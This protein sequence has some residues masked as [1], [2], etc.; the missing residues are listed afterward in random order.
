M[1]KKT[2]AAILEKINKIVQ[3]TSTQAVISTIKKFHQNSKI[4]KV[5]KKFIEKLLQTKGGKAIQAFKSWK[6]I[7][8]STSKGKYKNYQKFYFKLENFYKDRLKFAHS[9]FS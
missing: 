1:N 5:Q 8:Y 7:P 9:T 3:S 6:S 4:Q 2:K